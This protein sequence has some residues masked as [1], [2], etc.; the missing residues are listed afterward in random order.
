MSTDTH[1][2]QSVQ[3]LA[4]EVSADYYTTIVTIFQLPKPTTSLNGPFKVGPIG[5]PLREILLYITQ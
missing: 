5:G 3:L 4:S 1:A 2:Y